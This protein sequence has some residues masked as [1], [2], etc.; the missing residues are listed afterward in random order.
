MTEDIDTYR[1]RERLLILK[2]AI[3]TRAL[4]W[5]AEPQ[6]YGR[7]ADHITIRTPRLKEPRGHPLMKARRALERMR[8]VK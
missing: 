6:N 2:L 5:Y 7:A 3:A 4:S 8:K 1:E